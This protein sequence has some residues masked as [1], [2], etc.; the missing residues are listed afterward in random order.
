MDLI[1]L[2]NMIDAGLNLSLKPTPRMS[3]TLMGNALWLANTSDNFYTVAGAPRGGLAATPNNG[4]GINPGYSSFLGTEVT[5]IAGYAVTKYAQIEAGYGH[6]FRADY[7]KSTWSA[8]GFGSRDA[9][10]TYVQ[11]NLTF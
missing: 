3:V 7:I 9:D 6:F 5:I 1:S 11:L 4:Y 10:F 8:P 2:Q